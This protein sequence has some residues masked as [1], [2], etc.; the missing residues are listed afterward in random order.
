MSFYAQ[1]Y[2]GDLQ[3]RQTSNETIAMTVVQQLAPAAMNAVLVIVYLVVMLFYS[4]PLALV[5]RGE[6]A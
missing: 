1:R 3:R 2:V 6:A 4:V 5:G